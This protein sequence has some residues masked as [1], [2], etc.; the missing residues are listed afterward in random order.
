MLAPGLIRL[1][2][3][4]APPLAATT[5]KWSWWRVAWPSRRW[6]QARARNASFSAGCPPRAFMMRLAR[7]LF[8][9]ASEPHVSGP[10][11]TERPDECHPNFT[12]VD[13]PLSVVVATLAQLLN[14]RWSPVYSGTDHAS[15]HLRNGGQFKLTD[16]FWVRGIGH[17][18]DTA[19]S[20]AHKRHP[21]GTRMWDHAAQLRS[22]DDF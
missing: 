8:M 13:D 22:E 11:G 5:R 10:R 4:R 3:A 19:S 7:F 12:V 15:C 2:L 21:V 9:L 20:G 18:R 17:P 6:R 16:T 14:Q 1:L